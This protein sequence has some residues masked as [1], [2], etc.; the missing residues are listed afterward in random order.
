[1]EKRIASYQKSAEFISKQYDNQKKIADNI[2]KNDQKIEEQQS[3]ATKE[4][5]DL[6]KEINHQQNEIHDLQQYSR[7]DS[8]EVSEIP[9][10]EGENPEEIILKICKEIGVRVNTHEIVACH[11]LRSTKGNPAIIAKFFNRKIEEQIMFSR[12]NLKIK[13]IESFGFDVADQEKKNK[14]FINESLCPYY[15]YN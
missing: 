15:I 5:E 2:L 7:Q 9:Q 13:T 1:M 6:K 3:Q 12:K 14:I 4:M 8:I 11:R 10:K